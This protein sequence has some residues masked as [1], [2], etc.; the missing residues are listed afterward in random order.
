VERLNR[1]TAPGPAEQ[2][3]LTDGRLKLALTP[4]ALV[5]VKVEAAH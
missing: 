4:N 5:L 2:T 3:H 1:E